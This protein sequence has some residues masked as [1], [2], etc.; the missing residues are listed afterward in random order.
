[1]SSKHNSRHHVSWLGYNT[2]QT[3]TPWMCLILFWH[4]FTLSSDIFFIPL[5]LV[6]PEEV[7]LPFHHPL[8]WKYTH[9]NDIIAH[10]RRTYLSHQQIL[11]NEL[12]YLSKCNE[13]L[14]FRSENNPVLRHI[15]DKDICGGISN[16]VYSEISPVLYRQVSRFRRKFAETLQ[17]K[18][19]GVCAALTHLSLSIYWQGHCWKVPDAVCTRGKSYLGMSETALLARDHIT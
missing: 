19:K 12:P 17:K 16:H 7:F 14:V 4:S 15:K 6:Y 2:G 11:T 13:F 5:Q 10:N 1:M 3:C 9:F 18:T 8:I